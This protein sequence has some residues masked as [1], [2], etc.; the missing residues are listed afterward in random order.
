MVHIEELQ[1][2]FSVKKL[3]TLLGAALLSLWVVAAAGS[4][5]AASGYKFCDKGAPSVEVMAVRAEKSLAI[6]PKGYHPMEGCRAAPIHFMLAWQEE[7]R[8]LA[9]PEV[10]EVPGFFRKLTRMPAPTDTTMEFYSACIKG[11]ANGGYDVVNGC[12]SRPL[13]PG[14]EIYGLNGVPML[15]DNCANPGGTPNEPVIVTSTEPDCV[16]ARAHSK[17]HTHAIRTFLLGSKPLPFASVKKCLAYKRP[18]DAEFTYVWPKD[19]KYGLWKEADGGDTTCD[20]RDVVAHFRTPLQMQGGV[21]PKEGELGYFEWQLPGE[22]A[23]EGS[24]YMFGICPEEREELADGTIEIRHGNSMATTWADFQRPQV[25]ES[26]LKRV[27]F[28]DAIFNQ[29]PGMTLKAER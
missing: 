6:D 22:V 21:M 23:L 13:R 7:R 28:P 14:E 4:A 25:E 3:I 8:E 9:P 27:T 5:S 24:D 2:M 16:T 26:G 1:E 19:C 12:V 20:L 15:Q 17:E 10:S 18:G 11:T 29:T